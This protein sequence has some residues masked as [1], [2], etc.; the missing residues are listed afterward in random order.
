MKDLNISTRLVAAFA[1]L[2]GL[3]LA[4]GALSATRAVSVR[5]QLLDRHPGRMRQQQARLEARIV[6]AGGSQGDRSVAEQR[7]VARG[8]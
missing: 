3:L 2:L 1:V 6:D 4:I 5:D 8:P 7:V